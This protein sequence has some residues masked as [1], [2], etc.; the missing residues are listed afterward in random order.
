MTAT[1]P[2][3][4]RLQTLYGTTPEATKKVYIAVGA[5]IAVGL[6]GFFL[7]KYLKKKRR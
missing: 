3:D 5:G 4:F 2:T 1:L 6:A 7:V